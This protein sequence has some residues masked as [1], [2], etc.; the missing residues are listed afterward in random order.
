[1]F[2]PRAQA[3]VRIISPSGRAKRW[4]EG[5]GERLGG[6]VVTQREKRKA[7]RSLGEVKSLPLGLTVREESGTVCGHDDAV[8]LSSPGAVDGGDA[9]GG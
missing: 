3:T 2:P 1:M 9:D 4:K 8:S 6:T 7:A 5:K